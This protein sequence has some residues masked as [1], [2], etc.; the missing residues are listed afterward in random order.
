[1]NIRILELLAEHLEK[2]DLLSKLIE[3]EFLHG[4][5]YSE[6][7]CIDAIGVL[8]TPNVTNIANHLKMT[9]GAISKITKKQIMAGLIE[10]YSL[11]DNKKEIY[12]KLTRD[13]QKL[14]DEHKQRHEIWRKRDSAFLNQYPENKLA[15]ICTFLE[16]FNEYLGEQIEFISK[17]K[18]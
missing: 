18:R 14:F 15:E 7:H 5:G 2:Q 10:S 3:K 9:R 17:E 13:G 8:D 12:F 6:I 1:M 4:Y 16:E 11:E